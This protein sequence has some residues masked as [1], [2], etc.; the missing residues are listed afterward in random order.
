LRS[1]NNELANHNGSPNRAAFDAGKSGLI[2]GSICL[3]LLVGFGSGCGEGG[4][5]PDVAQDESAAGAQPATAVPQGPVRIDDSGWRAFREFGDRIE[6]GESLT[7]EEMAALDDHQAFGIWNRC[8]GADAAVNRRSGYRLEATFWSELGRTGRQK[9]APQDAAL[10][11]SY[12]YSWKARHTVDRQ[13]TEWAD[14]ERQ[15]RLISQINLWI[16][17]AKIPGP[18]AIRFMPTN[19]ELRYCD[20]LVIV[21]TGV[22]VAG[23]NRQLSRQLAALLYRNL[24][25]APRGDSTAATGEATIANTFE[26]L[27]DEGVAAWIENAPNTYFNPNHY[28]LS[29]IEFVPEQFFRAGVRAMQVVNQNLAAMFRKPAVLQKN[30]PTFTKDVATAGGLAQAGYAMA[31]TI[32]HHLGQERLVAVRRSVPDFVAAYQEAALLNPENRP[33]PGTTDAPLAASM[34]PFHPEVF[35]SLMALLE[36]EFPQ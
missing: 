25:I 20:G 8:L 31:A 13:L 36:A 33:V 35:P 21:D 18:L 9:V 14:Q 4:K 10:V 7:R 27:K 5:S 15:Q 19:P 11:R 1:I 22:L 6:G 3:M 12:R 23:G 24:E 30:G 34:G 16:D 2:I 29:T 17:P 28:F 32:S 26:V